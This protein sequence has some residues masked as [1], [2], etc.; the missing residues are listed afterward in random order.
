MLLSASAVAIAVCAAAAGSYVAVRN[1][2]RGQVDDRL[3]A[4]A[5]GIGHLPPVAGVATG[6]VIRS[7]LRELPADVAPA[8][9]GGDGATFVQRISPSGAPSELLRAESPLPVTPADREIAI[10]GEGRELVDRE[11]GGDQVRVITAPLE[12]GGAI[13]FAT[14]LEG[15]DD[16]LHRLRLVLILVIA[17]GIALAAFLAWVLS[18]TVIAP[19]TQLTQAAEHISQTQDLSRRIDAPGED[20]VGRLARRFNAMLETIASSQAALARSVSAQRQL[21]A[22]ASHELRTPVASLRTDIESLLEHPELAPDER[23]RTLAETEARIE[24]LT[25]LINDVIELGRG[26]EPDGRVEDV[27]LD[28][29]VAGCVA[30]MRRLAPE[31]MIELR[32]EPTLVEGRPDRLGR[33][34]NNLLDN[35]DKYSPP[36]EPIEVTVD[37]GEVRVRDRGPGI[38]PAEREHVFDRFYRGAGSRREPGSGLGLAIVRQVAESH[39]G[40]VS[41]AAPAGGGAEFRLRLPTG[42]GPGGDL[43]S[44]ARD[45]A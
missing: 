45:G 42:A 31:R 12:G 33:A 24:E 2:L 21:V 40:E 35:A 1:E 37:N 32:T 14:S 5:N 39:G 13:Q 18:R 26:D 23:Q 41:V 36:S 7:R 9:L 22:D 19:I 25:S 44:V 34:I 15:V 4:L 29:I 6:E 8:P 38:P 27:R 20:E 28:E 10:S 3:E 43:D 17:S 30:R 11:V 16:V